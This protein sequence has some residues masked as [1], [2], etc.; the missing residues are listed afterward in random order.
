MFW[1][2]A[3]ALKFQ[4]TWMTFR[5]DSRGSLRIRAQTPLNAVRVSLSVW[6]DDYGRVSEQDVREGLSVTMF[7]WRDLPEGEFRVDGQ[8]RMIDGRII[9]SPAL[10]VRVR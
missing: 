4:L 2:A 1:I 7:E 6:N 8:A 9:T 3:V 5:G 10:A